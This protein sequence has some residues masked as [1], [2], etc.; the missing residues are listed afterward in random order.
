MWRLMRIIHDLGLV[1]VTK[2]VQIYEKVRVD[3]IVNQAD[4]PKILAG[5]GTLPLKLVGLC[6]FL[7]SLVLLGTGNYGL[8]WGRQIRGGNRKFWGIR[9]ERTDFS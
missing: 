5:H 7:V 9:M 3:M 8:G 6:F 1:R 2:R 4:T